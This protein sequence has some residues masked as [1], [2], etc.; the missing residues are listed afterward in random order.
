MTQA[1][2][3]LNTLVWLVVFAYL[4]FVHFTMRDGRWVMAAFVLDLT[5]GVLLLRVFMLTSRNRQQRRVVLSHARQL[6][7]QGFE[8]Y[9]KTLLEDLGWEQVS[10]TGRSGDGGID[11]RG[12]WNGEPWIV[13]CKHRSTYNDLVEP[14]HV[15]DLCGTLAQELMHGRAARA[16]LVTT[17]H[18]GPQ[19][20]ELA[21]KNP[22]MLWDG[23]ELARQRLLAEA[24]RQKR[25]AG[26]I[27]G[28]PQPV[29]Q[30]RLSRRWGLAF[31]SVN[32]LVFVW[33]LAG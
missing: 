19:S 11:L 31:L 4:L 20:H 18:F 14:A 2:K 10:H 3:C 22:I 13:Q 25:E 6:P 24:A 28:T 5:L 29:Y 21:W 26:T 15:R 1:R 23:K 8:F 30:E 12:I 17:G 33:A 32:A 16:L 9:V 7:W 27:A